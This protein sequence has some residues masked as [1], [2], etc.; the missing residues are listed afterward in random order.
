VVG[1]ILKEMYVFGVMRMDKRLSLIGPNL[2]MDPGGKFLTKIAGEVVPVRDKYI[3]AEERFVR[4]Q[5]E[6]GVSAHETGN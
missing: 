5:L 6:K 3:E 4:S 1:D 2:F